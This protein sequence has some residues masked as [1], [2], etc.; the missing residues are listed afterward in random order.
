MCLWLKFGLRIICAVLSNHPLAWVYLPA[1]HEVA[2]YQ[3]A[4]IKKYPNLDGVWG[5]C[6]GIKLQF[7]KTKSERIQRL[8]Y[9]GWTHGHYISNIYIFALDGTICICRVNAPGSMH[10]SN[11]SDYSFVYD[12]LQL[13][14]TQ[15]GGR[16][17]LDAAF[18]AMGQE[19]ILVKSGCDDE[20]ATSRRQSAE[21]GMGRF[22]AS[23]PRIEDHIRYEENGEHCIML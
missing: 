20:D 6:D 13:V 4:A 8:F 5:T 12:K 23:F 7:Q 11:V 21:W 9:N 22:Q 17:V 16:V 2:R 3:Q 10:D 18:R 15:S 19:D 14:F 1:P